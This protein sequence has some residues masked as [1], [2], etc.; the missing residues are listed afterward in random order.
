MI[1]KEGRYQLRQKNTGN[2]I[3]DRNLSIKRGTFILNGLKKN[4]P[5]SGTY[6]QFNEQHHIILLYA[7]VFYIIPIQLDIFV[8]SKTEFSNRNF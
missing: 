4:R 7:Y 1:L 2:K 3:E 5:C 6:N 8:R